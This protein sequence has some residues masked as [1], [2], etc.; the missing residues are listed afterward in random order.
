[1]FAKQFRLP[2]TTSFIHAQSVSSPLFVVKVQQN[3]FPYNRYGFVVSKKISKRAHVR[4]RSKRRVRAY[5]EHLHNNLLQG[6]DILVILRQSVVDKQTH[7]LQKEVEQ[8]F[9]QAKMVAK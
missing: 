1:M 4:N 3:T 2:A 9:I 7:A 8:A 6:Y 5:V